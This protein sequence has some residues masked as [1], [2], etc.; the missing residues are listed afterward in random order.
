MPYS[1]LPMGQTNQAEAVEPDQV[2]AVAQLC[3]Q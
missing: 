1:I 2:E 3:L